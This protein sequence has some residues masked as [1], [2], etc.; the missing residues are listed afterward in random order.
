MGKINRQ[1]LFVEESEGFRIPLEP[2]AGERVKLRFRT[3]KGNV[4]A[5]YFISGEERNPM[6]KVCSRGRFDYYGIDIEVGTDTI[7]Y[8]FEIRSDEER[9]FYNKL[10]I[11]NNLQDS[12]AFR[13]IPGF[14]TPDW[15]KGAVMY[16]IYVDRFCNGDPTNDVLTGEYSYIHQQVEQVK[17]WS[18]PPE[19][20]DVRRFYG[21]DLQ[22]ILD[23]L[24]YLQDLGIEVIY[25]NP[26]FVSPSNHKYDCQD[27]DYIDP[28]YTVIKEDGGDLLPP[29]ELDNTK[30]TKYIKRVVS[31]ENLEASNEFFIHFVEEVHKRGIRVL[32]DGVFNHCGSFNKWLDR[33]CI[34]EG[35]CDYEKG[36]YV[37]E[38]SPYRNFF[39]FNN[40]HE[41]PYNPYYDGWWGHD[42][43]PKLSYET[44][45]E[46]YDYIMGIA[47][48]WVSP[49]YNVDG[50]RLDV[51]ADLG[52]SADFNHKFWQDFRKNVKEANPNAVIYAEHYG[53][54]T[55]WLKGGEWDSIMNYDTFMEPITW[56]LTGMEKHSDSREPDLMNNANAFI[57]TLREK[58]CAFTGQSYLI[59]MNQLSNHDHSRFL[60]RTNHKVG[61]VDELGSEAAEEGV[62]KAVFREAVA[63]MMTW[64]G[65]PTIYYGDEAGVCGFTDPDSRRTYPWGHEDQDLIRYHKELIRVRKENPACRR[66]SGIPVYAKDGHFAFGRFL[67]DNH[68]L[69]IINNTEEAERMTIPVWQIEISDGE[70]FERQVLSM[71]EEFNLEKAHYLVCDGKIEIYMPP[72]SAAVMSHTGNN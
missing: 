33:E 15:A 35:D 68:V 71:E 22:G 5:V 14:A 4:E 30:A 48:K 72:Y 2:K 11:T 20:M 49:P 34:Y 51:A 17:D 23:K 26:I 9:L 46:L 31:K 38:D 18:E 13:I 27:Y 37:S 43:L 60:T 16:Q 52:L 55:S 64:H 44:S 62:S 24:D 67:D 69:T 21:G 47:R 59:A 19:D 25:M 50:W 61:R 65:A 7:Y 36:A 41:W 40:T 39:K 8:Y 12:Y 42:T 10:S 32:L 63:M 58:S 54:A 57:D 3:A 28:H 6:T 53:D 1:A 70:L 29:G 66:G 56:Y 45:Q